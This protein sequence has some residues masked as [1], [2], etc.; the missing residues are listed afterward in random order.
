MWMYSSVVE[1][2]KCS[3]VAFIC[4]HYP[5]SSHNFN[6][7][8]IHDKSALLIG[9]TISFLLTPII[10][11]SIWSL[12]DNSFSVPP[13]HVILAQPAPVVESL[14]TCHLLVHLSLTYYAL[15]CLK[16][17]HKLQPF[18]YLMAGMNLL[19]VVLFLSQTYYIKSDLTSH[20]IDG[21]EMLS[22]LIIY[23]C[24]V[25]IAEI[26]FPAVIL[27]H[28]IPCYQDIAELAEKLLS[29]QFAMF[30]LYNFWHKPF[31]DNFFFVRLF[32]EL[33]FITHTCLIKTYIH[34][35]DVW[36][37]SMAL[38]V[39][40]YCILSG[41][42]APSEK[43]IVL[44]WTLASGFVMAVMV[45]LKI[46]TKTMRIMTIVVVLLSII[47]FIFTWKYKLVELFSIVL[48]ILLYIVL[49]IVTLLLKRL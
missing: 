27:G 6:W 44:V 19:F 5:E 41:N 4:I 33:I 13:F 9:I 45:A 21:L 28:L 18:H 17:A 29:C 25:F 12:L 42:I 49:F 34:T 43:L 24:W 2:H 16:P 31:V 48:G 47:V 22:G 46:L 37:V 36:T 38:L 35:N 10:Y 26:K 15:T 8:Q 39:L 14:G 3:H 23:I 7:F 1:T 32:L 11:L 20:Y 30:V 40:T